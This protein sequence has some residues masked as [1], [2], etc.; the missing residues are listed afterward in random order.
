MRHTLI[1]GAC[2]CLALLLGASECTAQQSAP[3]RLKRS[4]E[5]APFRLTGIEGYLVTRY[6]RDDSSSSG[7]VGGA[8]TRQSISTQGEE[9]FVM[10]HSYVYHPGL[11]SLD[12]GG[13]PLI[14]KINNTG[15]GVAMRQGRQ[16]YNLSGRA[17]I[18]RDKP[19]N[20]ALFYEL[21]NQTQQL[22]PA[23]IMLTENA[24]SGLEFALLKP[25]TPV[26]LHLDV[27]RNTTQGSSADQVTDERT[28]DVRLRMDADIGASGTTAFQYQSTHQTSRNGSPGLPILA[29]TSDT[30]MLNL[31]TR[32]KFGADKQYD[33]ANLI[34]L[35]SYRYALSQG[36]AL[37]FKDLR[38]SLDLRGRHSENL[39]TYAHYDLNS[40]KQ[41]DQA[42]DLNS[43]RGGLTYKL[44]PDLSG[45]LAARG[46][47][48]NTGPS[49]STLY[50]VDGS[51]QYRRALSLGEAQAGYGFSYLQREQVA[52]AQLAWTI[53]EAV[54]LSGTTVVALNHEQITA[55]SVTVSN[56]TR[57][58]TYV[59]GSDYL[60][61]VVGL[62]TRIQRTVGG[63][64][65]D[66]Q[67]L[68]VDYSYAFGGSYG[69]QQLD[70]NVNFNWALKSYL[71]AY[72]RFAD[73]APRLTSGMPTAP[74]NPARTSIYG[75]RGE[76]PLDFWLDT[77]LGGYAEHENRREAISPYQRTSLEAYAQLALPWVRDGT[78]RL[79]ARRSRIDYDYSPAQGVN[80]G[81]YDLRLS[82][83]LPYNVNVS[84]DATHERDTGTP[85]ARERFYLVARAWWRLRKL[86][87]SFELHRTEDVQ[88]DARRTRSYGQFTLR[89]DF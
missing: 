34:T 31:D 36:S 38:F 67:A 55:G 22:G 32:A 66:G 52:N 7:Q 37:D 60:L 76:I 57:S 62:T 64:I 14:D 85:I 28:D 46:E 41:A 56:L 74:L 20:G 81:A 29:S 47:R 21:R 3:L 71:N 65:L 48:N 15:D 49:A 5:I 51:A 8:A 72:L 87:W 61:S 53:G 27:S 40:S 17:T 13:G 23:Q 2:T 25:V 39:Q 68:L 84:L 58:Q 30:G 26:P 44:N 42:T 88:G 16:V 24:R 63:N 19:Y 73:S 18:L 45:T 80:L 82:S 1:A 89:R 10:T 69:L 4:T 59:E 12:L 77:R 78:L 33:L 70:Q 11:L 6:L 43:L 9:L 86:Q 79:G 75:S 54:T 83:R 35:N 50:G